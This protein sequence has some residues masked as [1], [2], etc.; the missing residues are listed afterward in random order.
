MYRDR[1]PT[2]VYPLPCGPAHHFRSYTP[3]QPDSDIHWFYC[4]R[5]RDYA[6]VL[7]TDVVEHR[8]E[9]SVIDT[10]RLG[11]GELGRRMDKAI[12]KDRVRPVLFRTWGTVS[13]ATI[14]LDLGV[15]Q[16]LVR[17]VAEDMG[18]Y[19]SALR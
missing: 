17:A 11:D 4:H 3:S 7:D 2:Y 9:R 19:R 12:L 13:V 5:C 16:R 6:A 14:A 10:R 1:V 18:V 15:P 8:P